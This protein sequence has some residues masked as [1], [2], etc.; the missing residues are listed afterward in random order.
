MIFEYQLGWGHGYPKKFVDDYSGLLISDGY[1]AWRTQAVPQGRQGGAENRQARK[2]RASNARVAM[3]PEYFQAPYRVGALAN[4]DLSVSQTRADYTYD[5]RQQHSASQV[6]AF[7]ARLDDLAPKLT[8]QSLLGKAIGYTRNQRK[9]PRR[10]VID[11]KASVD[12]SIC[13]RDIQPFVTSRKSWL[14]SDTVDC[15]KPAPRFTA[16]C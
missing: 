5:L 11:W 8:R 15:V 4:G 9:Y 10:Y 6:E 7:R 16:S 3:A 2:P 14:S 12:N 1:S 13:G